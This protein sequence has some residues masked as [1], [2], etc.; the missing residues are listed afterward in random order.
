MGGVEAERSLDSMAIFV[1]RKVKSVS[2]KDR[3]FKLTLEAM[4]KLAWDYH[5]EPK[6]Q[7]KII[8]VRLIILQN[9][10]SRLVFL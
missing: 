1:K 7:K 2:Q 8:K 3:W 5:W 10:V 9:L 6:P 4:M